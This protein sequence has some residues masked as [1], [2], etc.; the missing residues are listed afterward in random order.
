MSPAA[1][2]SDVTPRTLRR[3]DFLTGYHEFSFEHTGFIISVA[4]REII[5]LHSQRI[6]CLCEYGP[7]ERQVSKREQSKAK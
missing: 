4:H 6:P 1:T 3:P 5:P 7:Q 2:D